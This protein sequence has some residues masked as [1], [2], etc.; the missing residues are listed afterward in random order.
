LFKVNDWVI[1][2]PGA[3][4]IFIVLYWLERAGL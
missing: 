2:I 1:V 3:A 4:L